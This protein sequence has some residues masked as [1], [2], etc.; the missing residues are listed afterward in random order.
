[1][2]RLPPDITRAVTYIKV[3]TTID[4]PPGTVWN[5]LLDF[6]AY[7]IWNP[8]VR[9]QAITDSSFRPL[10]DHPQPSEGAYIAMRVR[11]PP[12]GL[13]D[14]DKGLRASKEVVTF[15]D[16]KNHRIVW[17]QVGLPKWLIR[18][19]RWQEVTEE[20]DDG[21]SSTKY[22][23]IEVRF[24]TRL[25]LILDAINGIFKI[26]FQVFH[27]PG[28]WFVRLFMHANLMKSFQ[29]MADGLKKHAEGLAAST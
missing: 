15:V 13:D 27:G 2:S 10:L 5:V 20:Q 19:E 28:A 11:V 17:E 8:F 29:A 16:V 1:M 4:A 25:N 26:I 9:S 7:P 21:K 3:E 22:M 18:A 14:N 6:P 23:T 24:S 12:R